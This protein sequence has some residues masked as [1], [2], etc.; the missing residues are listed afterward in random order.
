M[1][2]VELKAEIEHVEE[3]AAMLSQKWVR[4]S[5][6]EKTTYKDRYFDKNEVLFKS[7]QELRI[8]EIMSN[9]AFETKILLTYKNLPIDQESKSKE[10]TQLYISDLKEGIKLL[11]NLG[12]KQRL[13]FEKECVNIQYWYGEYLLYITLAYLPKLQ[14]SFIEIETLT[15][16]AEEVAK[17]KK[18]LAGR[19]RAL[20]VTQNQI[21]NEYYT[22]AIREQRK[23]EV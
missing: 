1:I 9:D 15:D 6:I 16:N 11:K 21:T 3:M 17:L 23:F 22:E 4:C 2:E 14:R 18:M 20:G 7:E 12:Y 10:E 13:C 8:R 5:P 19:L